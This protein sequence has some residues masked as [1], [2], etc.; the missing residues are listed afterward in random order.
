M[1]ELL[2]ALSLRHLE[3]RL[4]ELYEQARLHSLTYEAFLRRVLVMEVEGR[5]L[6]AQQKRW[7]PPNCRCAKPWKSSISPFSP[8]LMSA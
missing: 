7:R 6:A 2:K 4:P 1:N 8:P 5:K 3:Q